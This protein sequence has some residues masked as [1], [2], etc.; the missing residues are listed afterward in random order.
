MDVQ[1]NRRTIIVL[2]P[3]DIIAVQRSDGCWSRQVRH[4]NETNPNPYDTDWYS[5]YLAVSGLP[6][7][8]LR[9]AHL[10]MTN[11][12]VEADNL[13]LDNCP[14]TTIVTR[15]NYLERM[16]PDPVAYPVPRS[17]ESYVLSDLEDRYMHLTRAFPAIT[18]EDV[19]SSVVVLPSGHIQ[20]RSTGAE[21]MPTVSE[22][23]VEWIESE[24]VQQGSYR[25]DPNI[26][27]RTDVRNEE[28]EAQ[29]AFDR[30]A[31]VNP[32]S[33]ILGIGRLAWLNPRE[34]E[35]LARSMGYNNPSEVTQARQQGA[36]GI[37]LGDLAGPQVVFWPDRQYLN[38]EVQPAEEG[39][40]RF[41]TVGTVDSDEGWAALNLGGNNNLPAYP[42]AAQVYRFRQWLFAQE[43]VDITHGVNI[44]WAPGAEAEDDSWT[45]PDPEEEQEDEDEDEEEREAATNLALPPGTVPPANLLINFDFLPAHR[46]PGATLAAAAARARHDPTN[47]EPGG[48]HDQTGGPRAMYD[49]TED[50]GRRITIDRSRCHLGDEEPHK[51]WCYS[52]RGWRKWQHSATMD[53]SDSK[54]IAAL[55][56]HREQ[57]HQR[58]GIWLPLRRQT[59]EDYTYEQRQWLMSLVGAAGGERPAEPLR[60]LVAR[61]NRHFGTSRAETGILSLIDRLRKE[62]HESGGV[63]VK[64]GRGWKQHEQSL[65]SLGVGAGSKRK[66]NAISSEDESDDD[67]ENE[68]DGEEDDE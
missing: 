24:T 21:N 65:K 45:P 59:R 35:P 13:G 56:K 32:S 46:Q 31:L 57:T 16:Y 25:V 50:R 11:D 62:Y 20:L 66:V 17:D 27:P 40:W 37:G 48:A 43:R 7:W 19:Q 44:I 61:F 53:W 54:K 55:N 22:L 41:L 64:K 39:A 36:L 29:R 8:F 4:V 12:D 15:S 10:A 28:S 26:H 14:S 47:G 38:P 5:Q 60:D 6:A 42:T 49:T 3:P 58:A 33:T 30:G 1:G 18:V 9:P 23:D 34:D 67:D 63:Q 52:S 68:G 51:L 2:S